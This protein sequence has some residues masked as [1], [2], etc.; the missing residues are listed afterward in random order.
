MSLL[1]PPGHQ[2]GPK[3]VGTSFSH[4]QAQFLDPPSEGKGMGDEGTGAILS[5]SPD[6]EAVVLIS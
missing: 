6:T 1:R 2:E 4:A 5:H 3:Q